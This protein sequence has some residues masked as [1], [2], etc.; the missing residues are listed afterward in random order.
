MLVHSVQ[1]KGEKGYNNIIENFQFENK[2]KTNFLFSVTKWQV[3]QA[4]LQK[5]KKR[6]AQKT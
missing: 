5:E 1:R 6:S 3:M 2:M 4:K